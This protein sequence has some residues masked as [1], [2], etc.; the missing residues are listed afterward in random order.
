MV[1]QA[2]EDTSEEVLWAVKNRNQLE[3]SRFKKL[4]GCSKVF[5]HSK[6]VKK[7]FENFSTCNCTTNSRGEFNYASLLDVNF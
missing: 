6:R 4:K 1:Q 2:V 7:L 3:K 5:G